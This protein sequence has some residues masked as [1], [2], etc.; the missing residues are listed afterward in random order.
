M[1]TPLVTLKLTVF[2]NIAGIRAKTIVHILKENLKKY[3]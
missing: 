1:N 2:I 3:L